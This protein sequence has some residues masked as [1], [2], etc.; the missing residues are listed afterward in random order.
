MHFT[1]CDGYRELSLQHRYAKR[2]LWRYSNPALDPILSM[3]GTSPSPEKVA[4]ARAEEAELA[5]RMEAHEEFCEACRAAQ[6]GIA[7]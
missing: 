7:I 4:N 1:G 3:T 6:R 2:R 5:A